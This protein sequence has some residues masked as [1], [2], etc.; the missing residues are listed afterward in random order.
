M[1]FDS[2]LPEFHPGGNSNLPSK[3]APGGLAP[4]YTVISEPLSQQARKDGPVRKW[5]KRKPGDTVTSR[6]LCTDDDEV[7]DGG[8]SS[9][10]QGEEVLLPDSLPESLWQ[11]HFRQHDMELSDRKEAEFL[12]QLYK[13]SSGRWPV[14]FDRWQAHPI[15]GL[16]GKSLES[17]KTRFSRLIMKIMEIDLLQRKKPSTGMERL[18]VSQQLKFLPAFSARYNEK[19]EYLRRIFLQNMFKRSQGADIDKLFNELM[20]VPNLTL[21]KRAPQPKQPTAPGPHAASSMVSNIQSDIS[22]SEYARVKAVLNSVGLDRA[23]LPLTPKIGKLMATAE[24]EAATLL[25]MR[26]ALQRKKQELELLRISGGNTNGLRPRAQMAANHS[27][28]PQVS[29]PG[30]A[31]PTPIPSVTPMGSNAG[32]SLIQQKRKR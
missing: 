6:W 7:M 10:F 17:L 20:R 16:R 27:V 4:M 23:G 22:G 14:I 32:S 2:N 8:D 30:T 29:A 12:L 15:Y 31:T 25:M 13:Q 28:V 19:N 1:N 24:K 3:F 11:S 9:I 18:Q 5:V 26:D 21:K